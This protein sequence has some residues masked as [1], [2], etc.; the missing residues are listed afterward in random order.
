[1][2]YVTTINDK[3]FEI[4]IRQDNT[5]WINGQQRH[6]DFLALDASLYSIIMENT[7]HEVVVEERE[8]GYEIL[9]NGRMF[10]GSVLDE[11]AM[12]MSRRSGISTESGEVTIRAPMPGLIVAIPVHEGQE[13]KA[14]QPVIIL[15]SMKMQ[16]E[17]KAPRDGIVQRISV[18]PGQTV[19]QKKIL[20]TLT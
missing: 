7:S 11:R 13:V 4:E 17:L 5:V 3:K 18:S 15:E 16:N 8:G 6:V 10:A 14:G 12:L 9:M 2:K 20:V 19:E 1:V